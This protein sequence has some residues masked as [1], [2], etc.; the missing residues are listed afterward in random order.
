MA[1]SDVD[2][3]LVETRQQLRELSPL[4]Q[5][6]LAAIQHKGMSEDVAFGD[7][8]VLLVSGQCECVAIRYCGEV[9]GFFVYE[10]CHE[11]TGGAVLGVPYLFVDCPGYDLTYEVVCELDFIAGDKGCSAIRFKTTRAGWERRLAAHGFEPTAI[12]L[13]RSVGA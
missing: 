4:L 10:V 8:Y 5:S 11:H 6:G 12:E 2:F 7:L 3:M 13:T 9:V 1:A